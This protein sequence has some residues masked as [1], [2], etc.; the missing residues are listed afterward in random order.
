M[1][2]VVFTITVN[3]QSTR[4]EYWPCHLLSGLPADRWARA[5]PAEE[6]WG[7]LVGG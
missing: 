7:W 6:G 2:P 3:G 1:R 4:V 5:I